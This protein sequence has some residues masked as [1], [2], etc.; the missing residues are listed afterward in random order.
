MPHLKTNRRGG[1]DASKSMQVERSERAVQVV[2]QPSVR[3][4][5]PLEKATMPA[6]GGSTCWSGPGA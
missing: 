5:K 6:G 1:D 2:G 3:P 4:W